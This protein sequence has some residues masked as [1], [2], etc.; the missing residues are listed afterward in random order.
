MNWQNSGYN[1]SD[2]T[3]GVVQ[4]RPVLH[5]FVSLCQRARRARLGLGSQNQTP[6]HSSLDDGQGDSDS[7][8]VS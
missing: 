1:L 5:S 4:D 6:P 7:T 3:L 2:A 8:P